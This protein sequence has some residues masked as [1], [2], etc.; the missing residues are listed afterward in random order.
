M[1]CT[2]SSNYLFTGP[3]SGRH[4]LY[5]VAGQ[6]SSWPACSSLA[7]PSPVFHNTGG[8]GE[9]A[10]VMQQVS[11]CY[12]GPQPVTVTDPDGTQYQF[13]GTK[14]EAFHGVALEN[15]EELPDWIQD[16][17]GN[18]IVVTD[19]GGGNVTATDTLNR[20]LLS[21][22]GF[23]GLNATNTDTITVAG[24]A[25]PYTVTWEN[26]SYSFIN[27]P[28]NYGI[29]SEQCNLST[30]PQTGT[31]RV[32]QSIG[33]PN[34]QTYQFQ[35]DSQYGYL[36]KIIYPGSASVSYTWGVAP[37]SDVQT[38]SFLD[39]GQT[40]NCNLLIDRPSITDRYVSL[41]GD[42]RVHWDHFTFPSPSFPDSTWTTRQTTVASYDLISGNGSTPTETVTYNYSPTSVPNQPDMGGLEPQ[43]PV[44]STVTRQDSTG[45]VLRTEN[46]TWI[47][48][49]AMPRESVTLD[50]GSTTTTTIR[51]F[52]VN[53]Q[54]TQVDEYGSASEGAAAGL[55][56]CPTG[57]STEVT[58]APPAGPLLRQ[59]ITNFASFSSRH[60]VD[61][62]KSVEVDGLS[63]GVWG[64]PASYT[65]YCYDKLSLTAS[66]AINHVDP[67][68][69]VRGNLTERLQW[70]NPPGGA[71]A[72][73]NDADCS[74]QTASANIL[75]TTWQ[76]DDA[77][78]VLASTDPG[79]HTTNYTWG[80]TAN[81]P[82]S[83]TDAFLLQ[84]QYPVTSSP[85]RANHVE[86]YT[87]D[88]ATGH[89]LSHTDQNSQTTSYSYNDSLNRLTQINFP[90]TGQTT[91]AYGDSPGN[92]TPR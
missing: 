36:S 13:N 73:P 90:D 39:N 21:I 58:I 51:C 84:V 42:T 76:Y 55:P 61:R 56:T 44:E 32:I 1:T 48:P 8:D 12:C 65:Y 47:N 57:S 78:Q 38:F 29:E 89:L 31:L 45:K 18:R 37:A 85:N 91:V 72:L 14:L 59:T 83:G 70:L 88:Y 43:I 53:D 68:T 77:G 33:L 40:Q 54:V 26:I 71:N 16:R 2:I 23:G 62:P 50:N 79:Q 49:R 34:G 87:W 6:A 5:L 92:P 19:Q 35:Y 82:V 11:G 74:Q 7:R 69:T 67:G 30:N 28:S 64:A 20:Q 86:S 80:D 66:N 10:A 22:S 24:E 27:T 3:E 9:Y 4:P 41:A 81:S 75:P 25:N 17:N 46:K 52:D 63:N 60:I 15:R